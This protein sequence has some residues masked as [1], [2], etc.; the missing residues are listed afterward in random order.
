MKKKNIKS[1]S[2][3]DGITL[4][5]LP[6]SKGISIVI[7]NDFQPENPEVKQKKKRKYKRKTTLEKMPTVPSFIPRGDVSYIKPQ[8]AMTSL[9]RNMIFPGVPQSL[10]QL[11][12][13]PP[14]AQILPPPQYPQLPAPPVNFNLDGSFQKVLEN[15]MMPME[16]GFKKNSYAFAENIDDDIMDTLPR[17]QQ[18][19]YIETKVKPQI[20]KE[21][22]DVTFETEDKKTEFVNRTISIKTAKEYGTKHANKL[23]DF[24][25]K[26]DGNE[27]YKQNYVSRLQEIINQDSIKTRGGTTENTAEKKAR[28]RELLKAIGVNLPLNVTVPIYVP[29]ATPP[30]PK[31]RPIVLSPVDRPVDR[32]SE[33]EEEIRPVEFL[34]PPAPKPPPPPIPTGKGPPP[35]PPPPPPPAPKP[36]LTSL[37]DDTQ[38]EKEAKAKAAKEGDVIEAKGGMV[39]ELRQKQATA[40]KQ[41]GTKNG[42]SLSTWTEKY[43]DN[44]NYRKNYISELESI[45]DNEKSKTEDKEK[46]KE[47]LDNFRE[48]LIKKAKEYAVKDTNID[49]ISPLRIEYKEFKDEYEKPYMK[50]MKKLLEETKE[51]YK[52]AEEELSKYTELNK[53]ENRKTLNTDQKKKLN[54]KLEESEKSVKKL[55]ELIEKI[56]DYSGIK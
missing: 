36:V 6:S 37:L 5:S 9:N 33:I 48:E 49:T 46:A 51:K 55:S 50:K 43:I 15:M 20:E 11:P 13:P 30:R 22:K 28:A 29:P 54:T 39:Q 4:K 12:A 18:E 8:Y 7:K 27:Y 3:R 1:K 26:Y 42:R 24:D 44:L 19:Q 10:P 38:E 23:I 31:G 53:H 56:K 25:P 2:N 32:P 40:P 35:P 45:R 16:E 41:A 21:I 17:A 47:L 52:E 14:V 34:P